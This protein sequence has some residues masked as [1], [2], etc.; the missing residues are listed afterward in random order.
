MGHSLSKH[1][2]L[3][4][5]AVDS[6]TGCKFNKKWYLAL[7]GQC[8]CCIVNQSTKNEIIFWKRTLST[9]IQVIRYD[10]DSQTF[11]AC[12]NHQANNIFAHLL[13]A[14]VNNGDIDEDKI[15]YHCDFYNMIKYPYCNDLF[16]LI[17][18]CTF[19]NEDVSVVGFVLFCALI[20]V[21]TMETIHFEI[22]DYPTDNYVNWKYIVQHKNIVFAMESSLLTMCSIGN[23]N[24][25]N[26][27][28][29]HDATKE[30]K[31]KLITVAKQIRLDLKHRCYNG[32]GLIIKSTNKVANSDNEINVELLLFSARTAFFCE[33]TDSFVTVN[34]RCK[35]LLNGELDVDNFD[36]DCNVEHKDFSL[37]KMGLKTPE[38]KLKNKKFISFMENKNLVDFRWHYINNRYLIIIGGEI[39]YSF[40]CTRRD[41]NTEIITFDF[42]TKTWNLLRDEYGLGLA[43]FFKQCFSFLINDKI[44][45]FG[46]CI[47]SSFNHKTHCI[48]SLVVPLNWKIE[49]IIW[50][51]YEKENENFALLPKCIVQQILKYSKRY[52][53]DDGNAAERFAQTWQGEGIHTN[54]L[55]ANRADVSGPRGLDVTPAASA[56]NQRANSTT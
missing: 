53:F 28:C 4:V 56:D 24:D 9:Y 21:N 37:L 25:R 54:E 51:G 32:C 7:K 11:G 5:S 47:S 16:I 20:D 33:F 6:H 52:I 39:E 22:L 49:R 38:M 27:N 10:A 23:I 43:P 34:V 19:F 50:I 14:A 42:R 26:N 1:H 45:S 55:T 17:G 15:R 12:E 46:D 13:A 48:T 3:N 31:W 29:E 35:N 18:R 40:D 30:S 44:Y 41:I 2:Q 8:D 36:V